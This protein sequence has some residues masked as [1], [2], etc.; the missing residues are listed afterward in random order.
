MPGRVLLDTNIV[1][2]LLAGDDAVQ[3]G[4]SAAEEVFLSTIVL[5]ELFYGAF[6]SFHSEINVNKILELAN[7][8]PILACDR[9]TARQYGL[10]KNRLRQQG[11]PIPENDL[12]VAAS[13]QQHHLWL[14]SRD[15][16]FA[17]IENLLLASF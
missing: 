12:W 15:K 4:L 7:Q 17:L 2:A 13:A 9:E 3:K 5:G 14:I 10:I 11:K 16:H 6:K 1:I 8:V